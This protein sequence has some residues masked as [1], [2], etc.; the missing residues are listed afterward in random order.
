MGLTIRTQTESVVVG[1]GHQLLG[2]GESYYFMNPVVILDTVHGLD[3]SFKVGVPSTI[4]GVPLIS[5]VITQDRNQGIAG[6]VG[7]QP[8]GIKF[9]IQVR[10]SGGLMKTFHIQLTPMREFYPILAFIAA[11]QAVYKTINRIGSGTARIHYIIKGEGLQNPIEREDI[12]VTSS[13]IAFLGP[14]QLARVLYLLA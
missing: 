1:M 13:D 5:G 3:R 4:D 7:E 9:N 14:L 6:F 8:Q 11:Y 12:F 2:V 10:D